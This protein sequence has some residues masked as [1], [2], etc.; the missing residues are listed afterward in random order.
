MLRQLADVIETAVQ[1]AESLVVDPILRRLFEAFR[2]MPLEDRGAIVT[3]IERE[4]QAR[5]LSR[6][7]EDA[8]GQA[9]HPNPH[10][11]L[12]LRSHQ[13][14]MP[15]S[16]LERDELMLAMLSGMR[17]SPILLMPEIH[18]SWLD[19]TREALE[20]LDAATR[21]TVAQLMREALA[22]VDEADGGPAVEDNS[23]ARAS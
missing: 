4:V 1:L 14:A 17:A 18:A 20:H 22:L 5:R 6:A 10:A 15:R 16:M 12:Y 3:A 9:M 23:T 2:V 8:T 21:R 7:T 13:Q 19:G 11:R